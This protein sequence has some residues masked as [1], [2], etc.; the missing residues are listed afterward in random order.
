MKNKELAISE[1]IRLIKTNHTVDNNIEKVLSEIF[2]LG[3]KIGTLCIKCGLKF[4]KHP[5]VEKLNIERDVENRCE[6]V[7]PVRILN[8]RNLKY[9]G[10]EI[11]TH[12]V[13]A[14]DLTYNAALND[15][16]DPHGDYKYFSR[17]NGDLDRH[18]K[19]IEQ[20]Y[21][22]EEKEWEI[23]NFNRLEVSILFSKLYQVG[24]SLACEET[25]EMPSAIDHLFDYEK[26]IKGMKEAKLDVSNMESRIITMR[27]EVSSDY[28]DYESWR[29]F[30]LY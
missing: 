11:T 19:S 18:N 21:D 8:E 30:H 14:C 1:T 6:E 2:D 10:P 13:L 12:H 24:M 22:D 4:R 15:M 20:A 29:E 3:Y 5:I 25:Y 17:G 23:D 26:S 27:K 9:N 16:S 28:P 7:N